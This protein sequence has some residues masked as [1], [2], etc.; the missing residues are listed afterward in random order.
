MILAILPVI[1]VLML[2]SADKL[3]NPRTISLN[4]DVTGSTNFDG[5]GNVTVETNLANVAVATG[6]VRV[7][8]SDDTFGQGNINYPAGYTRDNCVPISVGI[9]NNIDP[10]WDYFN[11]LKNNL[12]VSLYS[13]TI[14]VLINAINTESI[15]TGTYNVKVVLMKI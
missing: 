7:Y 2:G 14:S 11:S 12:T 13:S 5:S 10:R 8:S 6:T 3:K 9:Y 15:T 4:G 1:L